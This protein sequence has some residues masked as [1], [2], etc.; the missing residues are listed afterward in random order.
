M[1]DIEEP[2]LPDPTAAIRALLL[3]DP[4]L[5]AL[6]GDDVYCQELPPAMA[7]VSPKA[8]VLVE[9]TSGTPGMKG[10]VELHEQSHNV[11]CMGA[12]PR[13]AKAVYLRVH[14]ILKFTVRV[15]LNE[16]LLHSCDLIGS[17]RAQ[18]DPQTHWPFVLSVWE[19]LSSTKQAT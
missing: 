10:T 16:C 19:S 5:R 13:E 8:C 9:D 17:P 4:D 15:V 3:Q 1:S 18:R 2:T 14:K 6:V 11:H 7:S 12:T